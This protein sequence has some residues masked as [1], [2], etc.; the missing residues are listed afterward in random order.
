[1]RPE[2][3]TKLLEINRRFYESSA[4]TFS[5]T[6]KS[7]QPGVTRLLESLPTQSGILDLGC[8][9]GNF[10][11]ALA[12]SPFA[13][14][15]LGIDASEALIADARAV[16]ARIQTKAAFTFLAADLTETAWHAHLAGQTYPIITCFAVLHHIPDANARAAFF[17]RAAEL[18]APKGR[19]LLSVWQLFNNPRLHGH[20]LPWDT[21]DIDAADLDAGDYLVDWRAGGQTDHRYVHVFSA[22]ELQA[23]GKAAGL[24]LQDEFY[25]DGKT[26]NTALY[27][28]WLKPS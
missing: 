22:Q 15:Y 18:L 19:L 16:L 8:G 28:V 21:A 23:L 20:I 3:R 1:M 12:K 26:G 5:A 27:Q 10:A 4:F 11:C 7:L 14:T 2:T 6:R 24:E 13:G 25:S 9:N 17:Q